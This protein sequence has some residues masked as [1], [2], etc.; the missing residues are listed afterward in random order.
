MWEKER[1]MTYVCGSKHPFA[2]RVWVSRVIMV[3]LVNAGADVLSAELDSH[4]GQRIWALG[5]CHG[6]GATAKR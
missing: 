4:P 1:N 5:V 3:L 6:S 2:S